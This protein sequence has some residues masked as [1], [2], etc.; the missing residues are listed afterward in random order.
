M[1]VPAGSTG[2]K[3][4]PLSE[5]RRSLRRLAS[6][7]SPKV[8]DVVMLLRSPKGGAR[9][10]GLD[11]VPGK[12]YYI[13]RDGTAKG[14]IPQFARIQYHDLYPGV[15]L[16]F[17]FK[18]G[19]LEY[20]FLVG[21]GG[22]PRA[23]DVEFEGMDQLH[24]SEEGDLVLETQ[25]GRLRHRQPK[26]FAGTGV[27]SDAVPS[28]FRLDGK[29]IGFEVSGH[30]R[31][32]SLR[33]D[34][35][36]EWE[37]TLTDAFW[38][39]SGA[40]AVDSNGNSYVAGVARFDDLSLFVTK[41]DVNGHVVYHTVLPAPTLVGRHGDPVPTHW[42]SAAALAV[43]ATGSAYVAGTLWWGSTAGYLAKLS[44]DGSALAFPIRVIGSPNPP[45]FG[46][47]YA[48]ANGLA[49]D[50]AGNAYVVGESLNGDYPNDSTGAFFLQSLDF[51]FPR[52]VN[53]S[54]NYMYSN[55]SDA[56]LAVV[57]PS[58][59]IL[60]QGLFG[61]RAN[62]SATD[63]TI[64]RSGA[65]YI[66][67]YSNSDDF[68]IT[69]QAFQK[70]LAEGPYPER[71][72][73]LVKLEPSASGLA[74]STFM[75]GSDDDIP[76]RVA[77]D[78]WG[79]AYVAGETRS[80]NFPGVGD[81]PGASTLQAAFLVKVNRQGSALRYSRLYAPGAGASSSSQATDVV[82][83]GDGTSYW[84][85]RTAIPNDSPTHCASN[86]VWLATLSR[87]GDIKEAQ[88]MS[89][90]D[91][92]WGATTS[93][94]NGPIVAARPSGIAMDAAGNVYMEAM[95]LWDGTG[96]TVTMFD[97]AGVV[98]RPDARCHGECVAAN[99]AHRV[100]VVTGNAWLDQGDGE[101]LDG[102]GLL[103]FGRSYNSQ[104]AVEGV[105][106]PLGPGWSHSYS[107][108]IEFGA[109]GVIRLIEDDGV[110]T[111]YADPEHDGRFVPLT[112]ATERSWLD[113]TA[114]G[115][116]R[117][118][119]EG[120]IEKY[121][122]YGRLS[123]VDDASG[124]TVTVEHDSTGEVVTLRASNGASL[125]LTYEDTPNE[126]RLTRVATGA[127]TLATYE[128]DENGRLE[129]VERPATG[130]F[131]FR[132]DD[133]GQLLSASDGSGQVFTAFSYDDNYRAT[134][135][136]IGG[137]QER[138]AFTYDAS[139]TSVRDT[140]GWT[141]SYAWTELQ[142]MRAVTQ[143]TAPC[144]TCEAGGSFVDTWTY[145]PE[146]RVASHDANGL[147]SSFT[148][149]TQG[150]VEA[151]TDPQM[152]TTS[153]S[154]DYGENGRMLSET[155]TSPGGASATW[156]FGPSGV[157]SINEAVAPGIT[158]SVA[159]SYQAGR[160]RSVTDAAGMQWQFERDAQGNLKGLTAPSRAY[161]A[162]G[163][164]AL[165]R[166]VSITNPLGHVTNLVYGNTGQLTRVEQPDDSTMEFKYDA[167]GRLSKTIDPL[168]RTTGRSYDGR[169]RLTGVVDPANGATEFGYDALSRLARV[170]DAE[171]R[172]SRFQYFGDGSLKKAISPGGAEESYVYTPH[173]WLKQRTDRR[174][175]VT[176][177]SY[178]TVGRLTGKSYSD[179][180][181]SVSFT[182]DLDGRLQTAT[183][184]TGTLSWSYDLAGQP[185][186]E[187][188]TRGS[189]SVSY[190]YGPRGERLS[191]SLNG[192]LLAGYGYDD[193]GRITTLSTGAGDFA[194]QY[195]A[196]SRRSKLIHPNGVTTDYSYDDRSRLTS[197]VAHQGATPIA[198]H[199][200]S[201]DAAGN[202]LSK[203]ALGLSEN[204]SY[205]TL[206]R[207]KSVA[208][209]GAA[210]SQVYEY[211]RVGNRLVS[212][213]DAGVQGASYDSRNQLTSTSGSATL[214]FRGTLDEPGTVSVN[215][216]P[217]RMV[218][219]RV[220][221]AN[222]AVV[223]GDNT[224]TVE[225]WDTSGN[226][227][228][229]QFSVSQPSTGTTFQHDA[230]GNLTQKQ[231]GGDAWS[232]DW[233]AEN[234]LERVLKNGTEVA[235]FAYDPLGRRVQ[236]VA[237]GVT[238]DYTYDG[239]DILRETRSDGTVYTFVHGPGIDEPLARLDQ[240]NAV[241]YY[242]AD[243]L[244]SIVRTTNLAGAAVE[245]RQYDAWGNPETAADQP[246]YAF[247]GREWDPE[248]GLYYYR[249]RYYDPKVGRFISEDPIG[250][251]AGP[252]GYVYAGGRPTNAVDPSGL[253]WI[254]Y[255][256]HY[257]L[258]YGGKYGDRSGVLDYFPGTSGLPDRQVPD[259]QG[260]QYGPVPEGQYRINL[261]LDPSRV[262]TVLPTPELAAATGIQVVGGVDVN[263]VRYQ[264]R[265]DWGT[266][267]ARLEKY[268]VNSRRDNFYFHNSHKGYSH[269]CI[270][271]ADRLYQLLVA[272]HQS[273]LK[274]IDVM[275]DYTETT[276]N[277]G[278]K[279]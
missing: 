138:F 79:S 236:K 247:T 58:G 2:D 61:G 134:L 157:S 266:W 219:D 164:D 13:G 96:T 83:A 167:A 265:E 48:G 118:F 75:G 171:G 154:Y 277:G 187:A 131:R 188:S 257:V 254:E 267:R 150:D 211:D 229:N 81:V 221:E 216:K 129:L 200:Y 41:L 182:Y 192:T 63:V 181:P 206:D 120:D 226:K 57:G 243:G 228:T 135:S 128:Y 126:T 256:G 193:D 186:S 90:G 33:I 234:Q 55:Y 203:T 191:L 239:Q 15:D 259:A 73:F 36:I 20:D 76:L 85:V 106:G 32:R 198:S 261:S 264:A 114:T 16:D 125:D 100:S 214:V 250:L 17:Y 245:N 205:D 248:T 209:S 252:N 146:G 271:T 276:T 4:E 56:F 35:V 213:S 178:D 235:R 88:T 52:P 26:A 28:R 208:R 5:E 227:T 273:G 166:V 40:F 21:P 195:D 65:V 179:G 103:P 66:I 119:R 140:D 168:Q 39:G 161:T 197:I 18:D 232:Y 194:L 262:A 184:A 122:I 176:T 185:L 163:R 153:Y 8:V 117:T 204:Y 130:M 210:G 183:N 115:Y 6:R 274:Y 109:G 149:N 241:A 279:R 202:R 249:A 190:S 107:R 272:Y 222:V 19:R 91:S 242:H 275:V 59:D 97:T 142:G 72:A 127:T 141:T 12:G 133:A 220:F 25:G 172:T 23:I 45:D 14:P 68:P 121:D 54:G 269:G 108:H 246:G 189:S 9:I 137:G 80:P 70:Q 113:R 251:A 218:S 147:V 98:M 123:E 37:S 44:P 105:P 270:E 87:G 78:R 3:Q 11:P 199:A 156:T 38:W 180:T 99:P 46:A 223:P 95:V 165:G 144:E 22:D 268:R 278:T 244:G 158:R 10:T 43:D 260:Q 1:T 60:K 93:E 196:A 162:Y 177:Y 258:V 7:E 84:S 27:T 124:N 201:Y 89:S 238:Y 159:F 101:G 143:R 132:Y 230:N 86:T 217:A 155:Y 233:D 77:V 255:T 29:R 136:D 145:T 64:D 42:Y 31:R 112:P 110:P 263:G 102:G 47:Q 49:L 224:I 74:Y 116:S 104:A 215:G 231:E 174:G 62:D 50:V 173:G 148:Y 24:L 207:L 30:D 160:V 53:N 170:T 69:E 237:G 82:V 152:R 34:P 225:A 51:P 111:L 67:G 212:Q 94:A 139:Q 253:D 240:T 169:G 92:C 151:A 175:T 71:D